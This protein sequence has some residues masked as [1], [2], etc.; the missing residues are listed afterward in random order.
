MENSEGTKERSQSIKSIHRKVQILT[1]NE[2]LGV[3]LR[4]GNGIDRHD[5]VFVDRV[6]LGSVIDEQNLLKAGDEILEINNIDSAYFA[7][8]DVAALLLNSSETILE[9]KCSLENVLS[10]SKEATGDHKDLADRLK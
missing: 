8:S 4:I 10:M 5:G 1:S 3:I 2:G 9:T 6:S 7:L